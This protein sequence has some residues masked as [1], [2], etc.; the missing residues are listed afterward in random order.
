MKAH[1][2]VFIHFE[3]SPSI[4]LSILTT[5]R[6]LIYTIKFECA[7]TMMFMF[8]R[9]QFL[10]IKQFLAALFPA[11]FTVTLVYIGVGL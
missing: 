7:C 2:K 3:V 9:G 4:H 5:K 6:Y 10:D 8:F 1:V 11:I